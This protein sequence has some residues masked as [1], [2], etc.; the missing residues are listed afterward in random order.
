MFDLLPEGCPE[1]IYILFNCHKTNKKL[2]EDL[3]KL[4]RD[5][6]EGAYLALAVYLRLHYE[7][8]SLVDPRGVGSAF[9]DIRASLTLDESSKIKR[10]T[11]LKGQELKSSDEEL[12]WYLVGK[13]MG[14]KCIVAQLLNNDEKQRYLKGDLNFAF[15]E[16]REKGLG[17]WPKDS[18]AI[19]NP[20]YGIFWGKI[21]GEKIEKWYFAGDLTLNGPTILEIGD[22]TI[23]EAEE[24]SIFHKEDGKLEEYKFFGFN[25]SAN[26]EN[27]EQA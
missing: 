12:L 6:E 19:D 18:L 20:L 3:L 26:Q 11:D 1:S 14:G 5:G 7:E 17:E 8:I 13:G 21:E 15:K 9:S 23:G 4:L 16:I 10:L 2:G 27:Y 24:F 25:D 22:G